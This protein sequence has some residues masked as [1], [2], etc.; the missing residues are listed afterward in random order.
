RSLRTGEFIRPLQDPLHGRSRQ[1]RERNPEPRRKSAPN[2]EGLNF[3]KNKRKGIK[4]DYIST[5]SCIVIV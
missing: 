2:G 1:R 5:N 4:K 3:Y